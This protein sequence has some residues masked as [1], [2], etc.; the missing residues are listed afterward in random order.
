MRHVRGELSGADVIDAYSGRKHWTVAQ[1]ESVRQLSKVEWLDCI[2]FVNN[3]RL[4]EYVL[5]TVTY[6]VNLDFMSHSLFV[7]V[8]SQW[9]GRQVKHIIPLITQQFRRIIQRK[10]VLPNYKIR[11]RPFFTNPHLMPSPP[12]GI[13]IVFSIFSNYIIK[14]FLLL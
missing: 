7:E 3:K 11:Y 6:S 5:L 2:F 10:H 12:I 14:F 13:C 4:S 1:G 8:E 9:Q